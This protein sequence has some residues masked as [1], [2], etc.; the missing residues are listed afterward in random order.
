MRRPR[1][2]GSPGP[3]LAQPRT[4]SAPGAKVG[5][6]PGMRRGAGSGAERFILPRSQCRGRQPEGCAAGLLG[7]PHPTPPGLWLPPRT[8]NANGYLAGSFSPVMLCAERATSLGP[9]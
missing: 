1:P 7:D 3:A 5:A 9:N 6:P 4:R 8:G 2:A